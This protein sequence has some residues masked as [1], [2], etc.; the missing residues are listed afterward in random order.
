M[1]SGVGMIVLAAMMSFLYFSNRSFA[2]LTN[3]TD[4]DLRTQLALDTMSREIRQVLRLTAFSTTNLTFQDFDGAT[5]QYVYDPTAQTVTRIKG[6]TV[7]T[8]LTGCDSLTFAIFQR[9]PN[10]NTFQPVSTG[11]VTNAK[12]IQ[13]TWNCYRTLLGSKAN[14]ECMQ[15]AK[16]V[17]RAK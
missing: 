15:S 14:T 9:T 7:Q 2:A 1:A 10:T 11:S 3:Y 5:L 16:V 17:I 8:L 13:L 12:V 6:G 4:L